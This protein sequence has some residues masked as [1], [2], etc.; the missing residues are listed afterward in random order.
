MRWI[1][2]LGWAAGAVALLIVS[3]A[4]AGAVVYSP[5]YVSRVLQSR[6]SSVEDYLTT[7]P[8]RPLTAAA[9]PFTFPEA[10]DEGK[11][12][13]AFEGAFG[14]NDFD[15]FLEDTATQALIVIEDRAVLYEGY[16]NGTQRDTMVT[17]F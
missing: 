3:W 4:V 8:L 16:F 9:E 6:E 7:F 5:Q 15:R 2:R 13:A 14:V 17:S 11:V 12:R 1:R 10:L